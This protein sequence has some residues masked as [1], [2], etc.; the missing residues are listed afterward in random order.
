M[1]KHVRS[2]PVVDNIKRVKTSYRIQQSNDDPIKITP[3]KITPTFATFVDQ[4]TQT[5]D[6]SKYFKQG[7]ILEKLF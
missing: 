5:N 4:S 6:V 1:M 3:I 7:E 2:Q